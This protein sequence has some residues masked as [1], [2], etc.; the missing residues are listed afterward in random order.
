MRVEYA[1]SLWHQRKHPDWYHATL[2]DDNLQA[3][4]GGETIEHDGE[5][6]TLPDEGVYRGRRWVALDNEAE[7]AKLLRVQYVLVRRKVP[8]PA[9]FVGDL[10]P[11]NDSSQAKHAAMIVHF[12]PW[13]LLPDATCTTVPHLKRLVN[14]NDAQDQW[15]QLLSEC[16]PQ[17]LH[18]GNAR[19]ARLMHNFVQV[20]GRKMHSDFVEGDSDD[21]GEGAD[22][23]LVLNED[24]LRG[25]LKTRVGGAHSGEDEQSVIETGGSLSHFKNSTEAM[26]LTE[27]IWTEA[28]E[29]VS[30][31]TATSDATQ[32]QSDWDTSTLKVCIKLS[33]QHWS[34][35]S[36][37]QPCPDIEGRGGLDVDRKVDVPAVVEK[38]L[39]DTTRELRDDQQAEVPTLTLT[40]TL[41]LLTLTITL[42]ITLHVTLT[43]TLTRTLTITLTLTLHVT[44]TQ[45]AAASARS[46]TGGGMRQNSR[47][48][49]P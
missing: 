20:V 2:F 41:T 46:D 15:Q 44:L 31:T 25:A 39:T 42:T 38:W 24:T 10:V 3:Q 11:R 19:R 26:R 21:D 4:E 45:G 49:Q 1:P 13:T 27:H 48:G 34:G 7:C 14:T 40:L 43:L 9:R 6:Y 28:H 36:G 16:K 37:T 23:E 33:K 47:F 29:P 30:G 22:T 8:L 12:T 18:V 17:E 5:N 32:P 35:V